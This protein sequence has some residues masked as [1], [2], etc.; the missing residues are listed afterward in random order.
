MI[1]HP[2]QDAYWLEGVRFIFIVS[3]LQ[4]LVRIM[5][6]ND[7]TVKCFLA[8]QVGEDREWKQTYK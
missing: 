3:K 2:F 5:H 4:E 1:R 8:K 7:M 6:A